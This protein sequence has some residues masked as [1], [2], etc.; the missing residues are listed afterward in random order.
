MVEQY[1]TAVGLIAVR[2]VAM[3]ARMKEGTG[4]IGKSNECLPIT[5][6][7]I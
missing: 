5:R 1:L 6:K 3:L 7:G 4:K 2:A